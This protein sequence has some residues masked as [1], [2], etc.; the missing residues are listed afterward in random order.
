[1]D[2]CRCT[3]L[4]FALFCFSVSYEIFAFTAP[5][6]HS[7]T[8]WQSQDV[9]HYF[10]WDGNLMKYV[11]TV[12]CQ[13]AYSFEL[14]AERTDQI[15]L[16]D[17]SRNLDVL[18]DSNGMWLSDS[19]DTDWHFFAA[20]SFNPRQTF[21]ELD[22]AGRDI[23]EFYLGDSCQWTESVPGQG[24][25]IFSQKRLTPEAL[26]LVDPS[27]QLTVKI[28]ANAMYLQQGDGAFMRFRSGHW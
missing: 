2:L 20:G 7:K 16:Q 15:Q 1:M 12:N 9:K 25:F 6:D 10:K 28:E 17:L 4:T 24:Q 5:T 8:Y 27:R 26:F 14:V 11:E 23:G 19:Q 3:I 13:V 22:D 21:T 18:L